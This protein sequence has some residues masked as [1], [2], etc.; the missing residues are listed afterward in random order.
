MLAALIED[1]QV[2]ALILDL[3]NDPG[4]YVN[5]AQQIASEFSAADPL[6]WEQ[7]ATGD[8]EP[9]PPNAGGVATD[10]SIPMVVLV[11]GGTASASEIVAAALQGNH[12]ALLVGSKTFGKGT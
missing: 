2:Q 6:Y 8:P 3:R 4:G 9:Q 7:S 5:A 1:D 11:N 10:T 12:R